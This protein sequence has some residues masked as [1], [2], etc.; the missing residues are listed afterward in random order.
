[1]IQPTIFAGPCSGKVVFQVDGDLMPPDGPDCWPPNNNKIRWLVFYKADGMSL[2]GAGLV[3]GRGQKWWD[4]PCKPHKGINNTTFHGKC[5]SPVALCFLRSSNLKV[6]GL[7]FQNSPQFHLRF[8]G[9]NNVVVDSITINSPAQSPNTDGIHMANSNNVEVYNSVISNGD[10]CISIGSGSFNVIGSLGQKKTS[11]C[12]GN[13]TVRNSV[14]KHSDN[15]VRIKTWQGGQGSASGVIFDGIQM[16]TVR[17]PIIID[18]Y[19]C[20]SKP[21]A[22]LS[23]AV[24]ISNVLY[25]NIN[26]TYDDR[27]PPIH[28]GC[29]E[30]VPCT[31]IALSN[32]K[33]LPAQGGRALDAF[34]WNAYGEMRTASVP[35][36]S[37]L[38][39]GMPRS[40]PGYKVDSCY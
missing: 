38:L 24:N 36:I 23:S 26:G 21:C 28:L 25:S 33:L 8:D 5:D 19:Y 37:C 22:N 40:I 16:D 31:N 13:V 18:Q 6:Y 27:R 9:C 15:G 39:E 4:L 14:V 1:M 2:V 17:N 20:L 7:K 12:V 11:A 35:P 30:A 3:D 29:S 10:D 34:C 32:V